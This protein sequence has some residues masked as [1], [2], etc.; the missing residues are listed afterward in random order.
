MCHKRQLHTVAPQLQVHP[1]M[2]L[3]HTMHLLTLLAGPCWPLIACLQP[4]RGVYIWWKGCNRI[5]LCYLAEHPQAA[6]IRTSF[7]A[8]TDP[9]AAA[10]MAAAAAAAAAGV[11][12]STPKSASKPGTPGAKSGRQVTSASNPAES[13]GAGA[14]GGEGSEKHVLSA[15][16]KNWMM[17]HGITC[18]CITTDGTMLA[19][20]M[21]DGTVVVW[22]DRFGELAGDLGHIKVLS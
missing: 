1:H 2:P 17:P 8:Q 22:D 16:A 3:R 20:G 9:A 10:A 4:A 15:P 21:T 13:A 19:F 12:P 5:A 14:E 7:P 18:S 6:Q 11:K